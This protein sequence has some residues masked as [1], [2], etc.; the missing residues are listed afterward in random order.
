MRL[1]SESIGNQAE[2]WGSFFGIAGALLLALA[3]PSSRWGWVL[4]LGSNF[5]WLVFAAVL[6]Y[7]KLFFQQSVFTCTS[8]LGI[9][10]SF[11]PGNPVQAAISQVASGF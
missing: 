9:A 3:L 6:R 10:N 11:F 7:R 8:L 5:G 2:T 1:N 4:F